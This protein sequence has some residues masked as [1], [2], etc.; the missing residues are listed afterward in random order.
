MRCAVFIA[1]LAWA[2]VALLVA[3][4]VRRCQCVGEPF[5]PAQNRPLIPL[6]IWRTSHLDPSLIPD[7]FGDRAARFKVHAPW[8]DE[9]CVQFLRDEFGPTVAD[10]FRNLRKGAHKADLWRYAIL[11]K[12]GGVY[13]DIKSG[14]YEPLLPLIES[15]NAHPKFSWLAVLSHDRSHIFNGIIATPPGNPI[16]LEAVHHAASTVET[17]NARY[18]ALVEHLKRLCER[19]YGAGVGSAPVTLESD[20]TRLQLLLEKCGNRECGVE[21]RAGGVAKDRYG[22]CCSA[23]ASVHE[24]PI[25]QVRDPRYPWRER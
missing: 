10:A 22:T 15:L 19:V 4:A 23:Y 18:D 12:R 13:L 20:S 25:F 24:R 14:L 1:C 16:L 2:C 21:G 9:M 8:T 7:L 3:V 11:Y 6:Q 5:T 17:T